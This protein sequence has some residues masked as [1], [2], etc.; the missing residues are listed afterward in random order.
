MNKLLFDFIDSLIQKNLLLKYIPQGFFIFH[1]RMIDQELRIQ[2][3]T[4]K[5]LISAVAENKLWKNRRAP[6]SQAYAQWTVKNPNIED[7]DPTLILALVGGEIVGHVQVEPSLVQLLENEEKIKMFH[8]QRWWVSKE[9]RELKVGSLLYLESIKVTA[10]M[11]LIKSFHP[12]MDSFYSN[13]KF[14]DQVIN[15]DQFTFFFHL[16]PLSLG[17]FKVLRYARP[18]LSILSLFS[19]KV[20]EL[21]N[22]V[23]IRKLTKKLSYHYFTFLDNQT[24]DFL[25]EH[26]KN[27]LWVKS[28]DFLNWKLDPCQFSHRIIGTKDVI[29]IHF[30]N[31]FQ[32]NSLVNCTVYEEEKP[33]G[34]FSMLLIRSRVNIQLFYAV[35]GY[36]KTVTAALLEHLFK[37]DRYTLATMDTTLRN[38]LKKHFKYMFLYTNVRKMVAFKNRKVLISPLPIRG[39][40]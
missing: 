7:E 24:Y 10:G 37:T 30:E 8:L 3:L 1:S 4:K 17:R 29:K 32:M 22:R 27:D 23:S 19:A 20:F 2:T 6:F 35:Q 31:Q 28:L 11:L 18:V 15:T 25:K 13:K 21:L 38:S 34:L 40:D 33:I 14:F 12:T 39:L 26:V 5:E 9:Y 36:E 16:D